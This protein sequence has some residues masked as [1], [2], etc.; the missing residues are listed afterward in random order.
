[1]KDIITIKKNIKPN[2]KIIHIIYIIIIFIYYIIL[3]IF[4]Y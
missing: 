2:I 3:N 1:L 4:I